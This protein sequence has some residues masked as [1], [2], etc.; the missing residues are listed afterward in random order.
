MSNSDRRG[1]RKIREKIRWSVATRHRHHKKA[2]SEDNSSTSSFP[3]FASFIGIL[4][5]QALPDTAAS[6]D[7]DT[8]V[9]LV[10][11]QDFGDDEKY[12]SDEFEDEDDD[13]SLTRV[14]L[15][16]IST[17]RHLY[18]FGLLGAHKGIF[19]VSCVNF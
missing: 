16:D 7:S 8:E 6:R 15:H 3:S 12:D 11:D 14:H 4:M 1:V 10:E 17:L 18:R 19:S 9:V 5:Q 2:Q 13:M